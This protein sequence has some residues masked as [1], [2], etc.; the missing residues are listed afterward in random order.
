VAEYPGVDFTFDI[1]ANSPDRNN[2]GD[3]D[4]MDLAMMI[5]DFN[6]GLVSNADIETFAAE[7]GGI[8]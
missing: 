5:S 4:G 6:S 1:S 3:V 8:Q 7:F 2:D